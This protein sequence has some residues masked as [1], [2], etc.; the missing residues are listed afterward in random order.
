MDIDTLI[1]IKKNFVTLRLTLSPLATRVL[2]KNFSQ[3]KI[4]II[5]L[6]PESPPSSSSSSSPSYMNIT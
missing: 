5:T 4:Y 6:K 1:I 3:E 2:I